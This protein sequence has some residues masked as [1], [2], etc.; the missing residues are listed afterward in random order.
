MLFKE[1]PPSTT[2]IPIDFNK[3]WWQIIFQQKKLIAIIIGSMT[4][5]NIFYS[6]SPFII[7]HV[8][9]ST[10]ISAY[11]G[12]LCL[13]I[14]SECIYMLVRRFNPQFQLR[15]IHSI[16]YSAHYYL[17]AIDPLYHTHR[18]SG[19]ILSKIDR[20]ARGFED[21]LDQITFEFIP[22]TTGLI[23]TL[24]ILSRYSL[25][26]T[27]VIG[28]M[29]ISIVTV[30][31]YFARYS[32]QRW[33]QDFID[34]DDSFKATAVENLAQVQL[35]RA[36]FAS[37]FMSNKLK[38]ATHTNMLCEGRLWYAYSNI[39]SL[40]NALYIISLFSVLGFLIH[41]INSHTMSTT[42]AISLVLAYIQS[43]KAL[44]T[45]IKPL[46]R[47]MRGWSAVK[48]LFAFIPQCGNQNFP[49]NDTKTI[50][51]FS[52]SILDIRAINFTF[53]YSKVSLFNNHTFKL[54]CNV[55]QPNKLYGIIGP[56]GSGKTTLLSILGGQIKPTSGIV[57][58]N[59]VDIYAVG[60]Q[61][62]R[63]LIALQGQIATTVK[64]TVRYN[65]LLG[66][67]EKHLYSDEYLQSILK[68][69]GLDIILDA[70]QG[71]DTE[72]GEGGH[73]LSGG[74]RQ[75]LNFASLYLRAQHYKPVLILIDEPTSSLD[76]LSEQ[77]I[78]TMI[79]ELC[80]SAV[81]LVIAHRLKTIE[82]AHGLIDLSLLSSDQE[83][84]V[85]TSK[86]LMQR[87]HYYQ[88]LLSGKENINS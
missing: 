56:S 23:T 33:E 3:P 34:T 6:L 74:Q 17:L 64:G 21:L 76:E 67:P 30:G 50:P 8:L 2:L 15:C 4:I 52:H 14:G 39:F 61:T 84:N 44:I 71:L 36:T 20:A 7:E 45:I 59:S 46:R 37:D 77:A 70:H 25:P 60:D 66:L 88:K 27:A 22:L 80:Q 10:T 87:L 24:V 58:I 62:R 73:N 5:V 40:F 11:I 83:I 79:H 18:S 54:T 29:F 32:C 72:L 42:F 78:T 1:L 55:D 16:F 48:D 35:V 86:E 82:H 53:N 51:A 9:T 41:K 49:I 65:L 26:M 13:F 81:T 57:Y 38:K 28:A 47:Y 12:A 63:Q 75:R 43:T 31:Y 19:T 85:Y 68:R 69:V